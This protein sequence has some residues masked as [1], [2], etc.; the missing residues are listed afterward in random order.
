MVDKLDIRRG[1]VLVE[2]IIVDVQMTKNAEL[3]VNWAVWSEDSDT[4]IPIGSFI[5]DVGGVNLAEL[6]SA[7]DNPSGVDPA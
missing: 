2:A 4:R 1:Q 3:G 7:I 5:N 6:A